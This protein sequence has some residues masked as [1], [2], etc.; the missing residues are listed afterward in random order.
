MGRLRERAVE[1]GPA[2]PE[3]D[4]IPDRVRRLMPTSEV[5]RTGSGRGHSGVPGISGDCLN[6]AL[7]EGITNERRP[8]PF[9]P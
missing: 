6:V 7:I 8:Q 3:E 5:P 2:R 9:Y 4:H 1:G